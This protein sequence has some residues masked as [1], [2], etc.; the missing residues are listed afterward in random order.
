MGLKYLK[1]FYFN[2]NKLKMI[3]KQLKMN[4]II[5]KMPYF[6]KDYKNLI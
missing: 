3:L 1:M 5:L 4:L 2:F 6:N